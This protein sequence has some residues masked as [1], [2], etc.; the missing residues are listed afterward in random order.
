[1]REEEYETNAVDPVECLKGAGDGERGVA[2]E[3]LTGQ[4]ERAVAHNMAEDMQKGG[5]GDDHVENG[6]SEESHEGAGGDED[7]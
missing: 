7:D 1:M 6:A 5:A 4:A 2:V 3:A